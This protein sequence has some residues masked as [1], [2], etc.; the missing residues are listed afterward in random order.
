MRRCTRMRVYG[1]LAQVL[2]RDAIVVGDGG[3]FVSYAG[4]RR[5]LLRRRAAGWTPARTAASAPVPATRWRPSSRTPTAR[6]CCC[7]ATARSASP[8]MEFDTLARHGVDVVGVMG[9]NGIWA[10]EKHPMEFLYRLLGGGRPAARRR[11]TT[12]WSRRSAATASSCASRP[13]CGRALERGARRRQ[14]RARERAHRPVGR[15]PALGEPRLRRPEHRPG[16]AA[17]RISARAVAWPEPPA[18]WAMQREPSRRHPY[19]KPPA[20]GAGGFKV[21]PSGRAGVRALMGPIGWSRR[22][23][24]PMMRLRPDLCAGGTAA[25]GTTALPTRRIAYTS[26]DAR[27]IEHMS[28]V[29]QSYLR[30]SR[31]VLRRPRGCRA[32]RPRRGRARRL[33]HLLRIT[34]A[35]HD[36]RRAVGVQAGHLAAAARAA[37]A[38]NCSSSSRQ[39]SAA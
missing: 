2:D 10:L 30:L 15:L 16:D 14:A 35:G 4:P 32:R 18:R 3:D 25:G 29:G 19:K 9:N 37:A 21:A 24:A 12:R 13:S 17:D 31:T 23:E 36:R 5:R 38:A 39:A 1:E 22:R 7:W 20:A 33:Q 26:R 6:S 34:I 11:A 28:T 8:G 27:A